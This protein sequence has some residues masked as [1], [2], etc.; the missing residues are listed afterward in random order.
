MLKMRTVVLC[1]DNLVMST[2]AATLRKKPQFD[3]QQMD[4]SRLDVPDGL[5]AI[6]PDA[7]MFDLAT[8]AS[9]FAVGCLQRHPDTLLIGIDLKANRMLVLSGKHS[10][11][12]TVDDLTKVLDAESP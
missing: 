5:E 12:L 4:A 8:A 3:L 7:I 2:L 6:V 11:L 1:G 9:D 10:R